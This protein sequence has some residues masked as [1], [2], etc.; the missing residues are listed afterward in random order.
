MR[1]GPGLGNIAPSQSDY[2]QS[3]RGGGHGDYRTPVLA[4]ASV[5]EMASM[6]IDA[7][8]LADLYRTPVLVAGDGVLGQMTEPIT[9]PE[10]SNR[11]LPEKDWIIDGAEGRDSR[12]LMSLRLSPQK[13]L[14]ELNIKLKAKYDVIEQKEV[15]YDEY[16][17]DDAE[18]ILVAFGTASRVA[19]ASIEIARS[20]GIEIGL[21]N[22][23]QMIDDVRLAVNGGK[24]VYF[25]GRTAGM[26]PDE[27]ELLQK[28]SEV[29][30]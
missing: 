8:D 22:M 5:G 15:R 6:M 13:A 9:L 7:F 29:A 23:G 12:V 20:R 16:R 2:Y 28:I 26:L 24:A 11:K 18:Y 14:E 27:D 3:T 25:Y 10:P 30:R 17:T 4:P 19:K 21:M 1:G